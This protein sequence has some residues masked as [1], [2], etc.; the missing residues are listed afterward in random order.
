[1]AREVN[2]MGLDFGR[3]RDGRRYLGEKT[4]EKGL[5]C[6]GVLIKELEGAGV[7][8][9]MTLRSATPWS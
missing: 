8:R 1:M 2:A 5:F 3:A 7:P 4:G 6:E 9:S